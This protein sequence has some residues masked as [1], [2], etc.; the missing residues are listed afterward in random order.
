MTTLVISIGFIAFIGGF[1][2]QFYFVAEYARK[3]TEKALAIFYR[4]HPME[5]TMF[6]NKIALAETKKEI[7][8]Q[9]QNEL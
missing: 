9:K 1:V 5:C 3:K 2:G 6:L 8:I 4:D 7:E